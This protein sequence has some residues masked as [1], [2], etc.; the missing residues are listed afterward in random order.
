MAAAQSAFDRR[1]L[2]GPFDI[3]GDVHGCCDEL[4]L[5]LEQLGY[6]VAW[7]AD[8]SVTVSPPAGRTLVF[9]GDLV[10]RGPR[11]PDVLRIAMSMAAAGTALCVEGNHDNKFSRWLGGAHVK[12]A[13]GLQASIDQMAEEDP[14]F[15]ARVRAYLSSLPIYLWLDGGRLVVAHAGLK[16]EMAGKEG[17]KVKSFALYGDTT[18]ETDGYGSPVRRNWALEHPGDPAIVYGHVAAPDVQAVNNTWCIDTGCCFGGKLTALRWPEREI[19]SVGA[20]KTWFE[21]NRPLA[22]RLR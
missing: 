16:A 6:V 21:G 14:A 20:R 1:E 11:S 9:V 5:L 15:R 10:D 17:G 12:V 22:G 19:V 2:T 8:R 13:H 3:V 4:E 18:G 7:A